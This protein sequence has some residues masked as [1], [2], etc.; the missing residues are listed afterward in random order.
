MPALN[1]KQAAFVREYLL[2]GNA[3]QAAVRAGYSAS[4]A[5]QQGSRLLTNADVQAAIAKGRVKVIE[6][7][8]AKFDLTLDRL[9]A[10]YQRIAMTGMSRFT[11]IDPDGTP[12]IDLS[13]CTPEDL[14]LLAEVTVEEFTTGRGEDAREVRR[15]KIKP[16]DRLNAMEKLGKHLGMADKAGNEA[17]SD[18]ASALGAIA[19]TG[20]SAPVKGS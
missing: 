6:R 16:L 20:S 4:T 12:R 19:R 15:V 9:L 8:E 18:L 11:H 17:I 1:D 7:A 5:K 10:E 14:D 2:S 3:T 13:D